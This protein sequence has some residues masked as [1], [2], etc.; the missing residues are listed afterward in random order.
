MGLELWSHKAGA[1]GE[2]EKEL[3]G[4]EWNE[5][6]RFALAFSDHPLPAQRGTVTFATSSY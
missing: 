3:E 2:S 5:I 1:T 6:L 4:F